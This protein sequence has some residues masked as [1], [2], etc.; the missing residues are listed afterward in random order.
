LKKEK[1]KHLVEDKIGAQNVCGQ[2]EKSTC[3]SLSSV[4]REVEKEPEL[5]EAAGPM[6]ETVQ[7]R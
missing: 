1:K 7:L 4:K 3:A 5:V 6:S 2:M